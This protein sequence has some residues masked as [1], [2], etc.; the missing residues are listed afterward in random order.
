MMTATVTS[1]RAELRHD[2]TDVATPTPRLT[3]T[4]ASDE[5]DW[6][7]T[8]AELR[9]DGERSVVVEG[10][11]AVLVD[12]PFEPIG[13]RSRHSV[14]VRVAGP[15]AQLSAWSEPLEVSAAFLADGEWT[16]PMIGLAEPDRAAQPVLLRTE[17]DAHSDVVRA[18]LYAT[19]H[20]AYQ[21]QVNGHE[22]D[23]QVLKPGWTPYPRR[24]IHETTD[25]TAL[26]RFGRNCLGVQLAGAWYTEHY[27]FG[28]TAT[29]F[30]GEQPAVALQLVVERADGT[31]EVVTTGAAWRATGKGPVVATGIYDGEAYDARRELAGWAEPGYDDGAWGAVRVDAAAVPTPEARTSPVV[32]A[33]QELPVAAILTAPDGSPILDFG[34][35]LVGR[36]RIRVRGTAG[37]VVTL[38]HA[39]VLE[40]G[41]LGTRPLRRAKATDTY[42]L[43]GGGE[44]VWEPRFTF[45]GFRYAQVTGLPD[46]IAADAVTAVVIHSDMRRTGW[47]DSS[48]HLL[49]QLHENVVWGMRGNFLYLPTDCPQRDE[50]LGWTGD[51]QVFSPTASF[52]YDADAFLSSWLHDLR[53][54]QQAAGAGVVPYIVP[55]VLSDAATPAAAWGDAATVVPTVLHERYGDVGVLAAQLDSMK[56]WADCLLGLAGERLLWEGGF[57]FGDWLDPTAPPEDAAQT[58]TDPDLVASAYLFR[59][60]DLTARTARR[61]GRA[62]DA[63][64]Y[65]ELAERVR[66]AYLREYVTGGGRIMSDSQTAYATAIVFGIPDSPDQRARM[67]ER[68]AE[69]VR[70][71]GYRI[72]TG[73][74]GTPLIA[75]ALTLTGHLGAA[76][77]LLTSTD[78]PSWLY[79]VTMGATTV[80]ERWDSMLE[81]GTINPGEMTSFNHYALGAV[82]DWMHRTV[83][84]LAPA[85][86]GYRVI[87]VAP[88]PIDQLNHATATL[89]TP[90]GR[91]RV[92]WRREG[93][94]VVVEA[95][96]PANATAEVLL[97]GGAPAVHVGSGSYT[98]TVDSPRGDGYRTRVDAKTSLADV[99]DDGEAYPAIRAALA[100]VDVSVARRVTARTRWKRTSTLS[101]LTRS[102]TP[103][104][105][106]AV[107]AALATVNAGRA[108]PVGA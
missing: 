76:A 103:E 69:L 75:D 71:N 45:H 94:Q 81:D 47:F 70:T 79:P 85:E 25:V 98:W 41:E 105:A 40:H 84:G 13:P 86:P 22:V 51:I 17:F 92:G 33:V 97:P 95:E 24:L 10:R 65:S 46:P 102:L 23:D 104:A 93:D 91:A 100:A 18:T 38:R 72:G 68:L 77:R 87:R 89:D 5:N 7:Q 21:V 63:N 43:R 50:R 55:D 39:E 3:W 14:R 82:A 66:A 28:P 26:I 53:L 34:Q 9:L 35:N 58:K 1:L 78:N 106:R 57:Q 29:A 101:D 44:E 27:G 99:V 32:R 37:T 36:L 8:R 19:A 67:G 73:F 11:D 90:Y 31:H 80:W 2:T 56:A 4:T 107:A 48:H 20:G 108:S 12:W 6:V 62:D 96:V 61:L 15:D 16:A 52:L 54:E 42:T 30:Y 74:V 64:R 83:A 59:S 49:N 60:V 88:Q